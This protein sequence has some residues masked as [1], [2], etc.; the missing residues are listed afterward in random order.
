MDDSQIKGKNSGLFWDLFGYT[1][2]TFPFK[3]IIIIILDSFSAVNAD[4]LALP[5]GVVGDHDKLLYL[6]DGR[7]GEVLHGYERMLE[8]GEGVV[9]RD[10]LRGQG[11]QVVDTLLHQEPHLQAVIKKWFVTGPIH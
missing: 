1:N 7:A 6:R 4:G 9:R 11:D 2:F 10:L 3:I 5:P 8:V